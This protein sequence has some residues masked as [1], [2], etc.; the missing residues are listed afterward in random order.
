MLR[1]CKNKFCKNKFE[2]KNEGQVVDTFQ[3]GIEYA[4]QLREKKE[5]EEGKTRR[6]KLKVMKREIMTLS[7]HK[8]E[9]Q[10]LVN[11]FVNLRDRG[12]PCISCD[13][14][15]IGLKRDASHFWSQGGNPS[16]RFDL[17]NIHSACVRCNRDLHG[18]LLEYRPRLIKKIGIKRFT[19]LE[20]NRTLFRKFTISEIEALKEV[21]KLRLKEKKE[22]K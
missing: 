13:T 14:P 11:K 2:P 19:E 15:D 9:L 16:V 4:K 17:D 8:K 1:T 18:N 21:F 12:K 7:D 3:C 10:V 5:K 22:R 20:E 6:R